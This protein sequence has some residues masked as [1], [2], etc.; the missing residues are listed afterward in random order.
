[1]DLF[2]VFF[3][4]IFVGGGLVG[5]LFVY[6]FVCVGFDVEVFEKCFDLCCVGYEEGCLINLVLVECGLYVLCSGGLVE[7]V[8]VC[9]V[10]MCG[11][12]VYVDQ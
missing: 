5:V 12:M 6:L 4:F 7:Q 10:M 2:L 11:C 1:M 9:V 8:L 3:I